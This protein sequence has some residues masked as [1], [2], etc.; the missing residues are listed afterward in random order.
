MLY[1][2]GSA[3]MVGV[4][5]FRR[6][7]KNE[8]RAIALAATLY[9]VMHYIFAYVDISWDNQSMVYVGM[10]LGLLS[11]LEYIVCKEEKL[12]VKRWPWQSDPM[13]EP[14]LIT[15]VPKKAV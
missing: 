5:T 12:P 8:I 14:G 10:M 3:I 9:I 1:L 6:M 13:P 4:D 15:L 7:P 11:R 2:V